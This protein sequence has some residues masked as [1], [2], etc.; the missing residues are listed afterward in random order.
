M[1]RLPRFFVPG[2]PLHVIQRGNNRGKLFDQITDYQNYLEWLKEATQSHRCAIHAYVLMTNH[3]HLLVTPTHEDSLPKAFQSLGRRYV[4]YFNRTYERTGTLWEGRYRATLIESET[5]L[6]TCC[7]YIELNPVRA[8]MVRHPRDYRWSS[9]HFHADG[10]ADPLL[11]PHSLYQHLGE[12]AEAR[13]QAYRSLF[14]QHLSGETL[15][16]I[17]EATNK[18]WVLGSEKFKVRLAKKLDRRVEPLPR[19]RPSLGKG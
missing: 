5:Y 7:R 14:R 15:D 9:Y 2:V 3:V 17:R 8:E 4:Q 6:L 11:A 13:Q 10:K 18:A 1:A 19:G 12:T 16:A